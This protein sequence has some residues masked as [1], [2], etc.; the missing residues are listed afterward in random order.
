MADP[1]FFGRSAPLSVEVVA[2]VTGAKLISEAAT[3]PQ[4]KDVSPI[5][6]AG[7]GDITFLENRKY[8]DLVSNTQASACFISSDLADRADPNLILLL[9]MNKK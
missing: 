7:L 2:E 3:C 5:D 1:R 4:I 9:T 6:T 8:V